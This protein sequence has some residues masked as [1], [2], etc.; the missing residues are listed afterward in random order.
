[1]ENVE[2]RDVSQPIEGTVERVKIVAC[3]ANAIKLAANP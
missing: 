1:M 3:D 2:L